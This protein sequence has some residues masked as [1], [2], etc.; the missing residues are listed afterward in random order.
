MKRRTLKILAI[1]Y[2]IKTL[3]LGAACLLYPELPELVSGHVK[4]AWSAMAGPA[5]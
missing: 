1:S 5:E 2:A 4:A 3:I